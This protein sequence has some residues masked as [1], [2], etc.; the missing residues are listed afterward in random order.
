MIRNAFFALA[1]TVIGSSA[2]FAA[3]A[4]VQVQAQTVTTLTVQNDYPAQPGPH[5]V[6]YREWADLVG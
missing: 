2:A 6:I 4:P 1:L 5:T 3:E